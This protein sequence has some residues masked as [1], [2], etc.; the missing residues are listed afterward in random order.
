MHRSLHCIPLKSQYIGV[1][2]DDKTCSKFS[3]RDLYPLV[4]GF[5]WLRVRPLEVTMYLPRGEARSIS[6][7][8]AESAQ[9]AA[10]VG[11]PVDQAH[12]GSGGFPLN[13]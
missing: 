9:E 8:G 5:S 10:A 1:E 13:S 12:V 3:P 4:A 2:E 11:P 6:V 7:V